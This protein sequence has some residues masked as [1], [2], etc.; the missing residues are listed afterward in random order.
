AWA[1]AR[2]GPCGRRRPAP[3]ILPGHHPRRRATLTADR[4]PAGPLADRGRPPAPRHD[5]DGPR[6]AHPGDARGIRLPAGSAG[7]QVRGARAARRD[8]MAKILIVDDEPEIVRGLEDNLRFEGYQTASAANGE[9][10]LALA[11]SGAPDLILLDV[12]M[13]RMSG[14]DVCRALREKGIE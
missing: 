3:G 2:D 13:P 9:E 11:L 5:P 12:M 8:V 14:W 4:Q 7:F 10:A 6:A 1:D